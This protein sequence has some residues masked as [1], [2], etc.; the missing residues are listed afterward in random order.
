MDLTILN[1][2]GVAYATEWGNISS[3]DWG[4]YIKTDKAVY[5]EGEDI[6]L[7]LD[8][9]ANTGKGPDTL[10]LGLYE[11][12]AA[13]GYNTSIKWAYINEDVE[14]TLQSFLN[15]N[16]LTPKKYHL[17]A[18]TAGGGNDPGGIWATLDFTVESAVHIESTINTDKTEY[19]FDEPVMVTATSGYYD[20]WVGIYEKGKADPLDTPG[21]LLGWYRL[22]ETDGNPVDILHDEVVRGK[23]FTEEGLVGD[24]EVILFTGGWDV[25]V[26]DNDKLCTKFF[27]ISS[28]AKID[29]A[30]LTLK[31]NIDVNLYASFYSAPTSAEMEVELNGKTYTLTGEPIGGTDNKRY[32]FKFSGLDPRYLGDEFTA[33]LNATISGQQFTDTITYSA[34]EYCMTVLNGEYEE[35]VKWIAADLLVLGAETQNY[36]GYKTDNLAT[37]DMTDANRAYIS[38]YSAPTAKQGFFETILE[39]TASDD[40]KWVSG[41]VLMNDAFKMRLT[42]TAADIENLLVVAYDDLVYDSSDFHP[43]SDGKYYIE[44]ENISAD[45][46]RKD[47]N[48]QFIVNDEPVGQTLHYS[49][50][51]YAARIGSE[52]TERL[53]CYGESAYG[54]TD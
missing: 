7:C 50:N 39:G 43:I 46:F 40:Y 38:K 29:D 26:D 31:N 8:G 19:S 4:F 33:T 25:D 34:K 52:L 23:T 32:V 2:G 47:V 1:V 49:I 13:D 45:G 9:F 42:F 48:A 11:Y 3:E 28:P 20:A 51:T 35:A 22:R 54:Y 36:T 16:S 15:Y 37:A 30:S 44:I 41:K 10:W 53:F 18:T 21:W 6:A 12:G 17:I 27:S 14:T 5:I 24:Y